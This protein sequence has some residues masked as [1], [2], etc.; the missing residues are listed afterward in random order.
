[1]KVRDCGLAAGIDLSRIRMEVIVI[2]AMAYTPPE[3]SLG[4][5]AK[6]RS[7]SELSGRSQGIGWE[8]GIRTPINRPRVLSGSGSVFW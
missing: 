4:Q 1:V 2:G 8:A 6:S 3:L 7:D 5:E